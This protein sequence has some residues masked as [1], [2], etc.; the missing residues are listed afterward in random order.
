MNIGDV[1]GAAAV[2][3]KRSVEPEAREMT[4]RE[5]ALL[6]HHKLVSMNDQ[7]SD[8]DTQPD[9]NLLCATTGMTQKAWK[10]VINLDLEYFSTRPMNRSRMQKVAHRLL[11]MTNE[12]WM[13][14]VISGGFMFKEKP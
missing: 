5:S 13:K 12:D 8:E 1:W 9:T 14:M 2:E 3:A 6:I 7:Y 4:V 11:D 10:A